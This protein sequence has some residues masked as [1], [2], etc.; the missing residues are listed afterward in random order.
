MANQSETS[1][2]PW[3][4]QWRGYQIRQWLPNQRRES[5]TKKEGHDEKETGLRLYRV[6]VNNNAQVIDEPFMFVEK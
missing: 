3:E 1:E 6:K 2:I 4:A 5:R